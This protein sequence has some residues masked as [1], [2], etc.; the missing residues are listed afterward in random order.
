M[1]PADINQT[2]THYLAKNYENL[3]GVMPAERYFLVRG[4]TTGEFSIAD[5]RIALGTAVDI[6][7][8]TIEKKQFFGWYIPESV[9]QAT[10]CN[11][12]G[13]VPLKD[14]DNVFGSFNVKLLANG[15]FIATE[16]IEPKKYLDILRTPEGFKQSASLLGV[17]GDL[18]KIA[19]TLFI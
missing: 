16:R 11:N 9:D 17:E 19:S 14:G 7:A 10:N 13:I 2:I 3:H 15:L 18:E 6:L 4:T 1:K 12:A 5:S 8:D